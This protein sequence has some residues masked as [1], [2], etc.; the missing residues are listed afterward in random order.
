M[1]HLMVVAA[2]VSAGVL[3]SCGSG[4]GG[5]GG[6]SDTPSSPGPATTSPGTPTSSP[7]ATGPGLATGSGLPADLRERPA[8]A[9]ALA[10][11]A[12]RQNVPESR[13]AVAAWSP[14][15]WND[16]SLGCPQPGTTY[17]QATVD[18]ELLLLRVD[19]TLLAYHAGPDGTFR[20]CD[21]PQGTYS[22]RAS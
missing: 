20:Y 4:D 10:D 21:A 3:T 18:G 2:V 13:V 16:G 7:S 14:V 15:T 8:V 1:R 17:T 12:R 5:A 9:K 6:P 11:A 22:I 19:M